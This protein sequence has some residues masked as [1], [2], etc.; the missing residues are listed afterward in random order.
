MTRGEKVCGFIERYCKVPEGKLVGKPLVLAPFQKKFILECYDNP[1]GTSTAILSIAR[2]NAKTALTACLVLAHLV[3][4]E[5]VQNSQIIS[6]ARSRDQAALIFTLA[7]KMIGLNPA[8]KGITRIVPS[9]KQIFGLTMNVEYK[10]ISADAFTTHGM[11]PVVAILD[12]LGQVRGPQDDFVD[13]VTT[14]QGAY[15]NPLLIAISTQ[16]PTD[17]DLFSV[18]IDDAQK[19]GDP[20]IVC[21]V[22]AAPMEDDPDKVA[23]QI[24]DEECWKAAN[25]ALGVFRSYDDLVKQAVKASRMPSFENTF[26]NL[27]LN[28]RVSVV[29]NL[30]PKSVWES[31]SDDPGPLLPGTWVWAGLDLSGRTDL[32]SLVV[33]FKSNN[34][35]H[36]HSFFWTPEEGLTARAK[37]DRNPYD[38]WV[39]KG[40]IIPTPGKTVDYS[41]VARDIA[42]ILSPLTLKGLAFDRWRINDLKKELDAISFDYLD[43]ADPSGQASLLIEH[44]QGFKDMGASVDHIEAELLNGRIRHGGHPVLRMC[45]ANAVVQKDAAG[46]RKLDKAKSTGRIDGMVALTMAIGLAMSQQVAEEPAKSF[47]ES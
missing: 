32:T 5:A 44:G 45:A 40:L 30:V 21:H 16:A 43:P 24:M 38:V 13:A 33:I 47:W 34:Y 4:P 41:F 25:P 42:E 12:E 11:S 3:G 20:K 26:R 19:S 18:W 22:Y 10:A 2:K 29:S 15:E 14:A 36:A 37:R 31:C 35:W 17:G 8:L 1:A 9:K 23:E 46:S 39:K 7:S 27:I 28:Q 6:G